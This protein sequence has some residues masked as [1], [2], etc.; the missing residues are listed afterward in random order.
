MPLPQ[1]VIVGAP[2]VGKSRLFNRLAR[3]RRSVVHS[4]P[5][6]TRD[7]LEAR[8][9][10]GDREFLL[11]DTGGI[12][13]GSGGSALQREIEHQAIEAAREGDLVL[14][15]VDLKAGVT[16]LDRE[17]ATRILRLGKPVLL[18][19]N[20]VDAAARASANR[21]DAWRLG[22][23][24]GVEISAEHSIGVE[25]LIEALAARLP[26]G[27]RSAPAEPEAIPVAIVGRPNAGK[28]SLFNQL[29]GSQRALVSAQPGTTHD[30]LE[31]MFEYR[32]Q[33]Y[34]LIDTAGL[35]RRSRIR[36]PLEALTA[37][38]ARGVIDRSA[39]A[40]LVLDAS[41]G[42]DRQDLA[43]GGLALRTYRPLL[44]ALNKV[45]LL[46]PALL[47]RTRAHALRQFGFAR[48]APQVPVSA[49][50][51]QGIPA[52][53]R[54]LARIWQEGGKRVSTGPLN[55]LLSRFGERLPGSPRRHR[56]RPLYATQ[57]GIHP[58]SF[59]VFAHLSG[60]PH[61]A[62]RRAFENFLRKK[63]ELEHT[64]IVLRFRSQR[65]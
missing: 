49:L 38:L 2:N 34:R 20:K 35:R 10:L 17:L 7:R 3:K 57:E 4:M 6:T 60:K 5:G 63:L 19:L 47:T 39:I 43:V 44:V 26:A 37:A 58:P 31:G 54:M 46:Q 64:P 48:F 15:V 21:P 30:R 11:I 27:E 42:I 51:G 12:A 22:L 23:G 41:R 9:S 25:E 29:L 40:L 55:K 32:G 33:R 62:Y 56:V 14:L 18:V 28:S 1:I 65:G 24:E 52:L 61:F 50:T 13:A 8:V 16:A 59:V 36:E 53:K 45:D